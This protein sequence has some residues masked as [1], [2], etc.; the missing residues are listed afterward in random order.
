MPMTTRSRRRTRSH[1]AGRSGGRGRV[2]RRAAA[3]GE[4]QRARRASLHPA[5]RR[6]APDRRHAGRARGRALGPR[7]GLQRRQRL[8]R[9]RNPLAAAA[10]RPGDALPRSPARA[11]CARSGSLPLRGRGRGTSSVA[12]RRDRVLWSGAAK[13]SPSRPTMEPIR[14]S[15]WR[16][17]KWNTARSVSAVRIARGEYQGCPPAVT[18]G[19][20]RHTDCVVA[21]PHRQAAALTQGSI[22]RG[23][24]DDPAF[25]LAYVVTAVL[26]Q[27]ERQSGH[28]GIRKRLNLLHQLAFG[29]HRTDPRN[30]TEQERNTLVMGQ[31]NHFTSSP[32]RHLPGQAPRRRWCDRN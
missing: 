23:R 21:E 31:V 32:L 11:C 29:G 7:R 26:V 18:R 4:A 16:S 22:I 24:I 12:A 15:V 14:P 9:V 13:S 2:A 1:D 17:A 6:A 25:L 3:A 27:L 10:G 19:C 28:P 30:R 8:G 20:A 5:R